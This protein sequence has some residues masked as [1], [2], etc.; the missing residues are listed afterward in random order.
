MLFFLRLGF[1]QLNDISTHTAPELPS[2]HAYST[3]KR[4]PHALEGV[5]DR[6][7]WEDELYEGIEWVEGGFECFELSGISMMTQDVAGK[8]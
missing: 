4:P 8:A 1:P 5:H 7:I 2:S 3:K 6:Q